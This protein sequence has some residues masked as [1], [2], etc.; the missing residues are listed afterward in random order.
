MSEITVENLDAPEEAPEEVSAPP[1]AEPESVR[2]PV[3]FE[4]SAGEVS[5]E[6]APKKRGRPKA[7]T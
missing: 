4:T 2:Q 1:E 7:K 6:A 3:A 5:F